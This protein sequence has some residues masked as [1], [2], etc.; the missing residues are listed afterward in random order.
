[1]TPTRRQFV[2]GT[3]AGVPVFLLA[4][5][6]LGQRGRP[7]V[8]PADP[9]WDQIRRELTRVYEELRSGPVRADSLRAFESALRMHAAHATA[10]GFDAVLK[11]SIGARLDA[12]G[13]AQVVDDIARGA[14]IHRRDREIRK[15]FPR[16]VP[17]ARIPHMAIAAED[18]DRVLTG[19][20]DGGASP[21]LLAAADE[22]RRKV[23]ELAAR[24]PQAAA[25]H[26]VKQDTCWA[27]Q[28]SLR[29]LEA[30]TGIICALSVVQPELAPACAVSAFELGMLQLAYWLTCEW[31]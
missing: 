28:Q 6:S 10:T 8:P 15:Q 12:V 2:A 26:R 1:M 30:L 27:M 19:V 4:P 29:A 9:V 24:Q 11:R 23:E 5:T 25:F 18:I 22:L 16:F 3:L 14:H 20:V 17:D 21:I 13:R 7:P 31:L